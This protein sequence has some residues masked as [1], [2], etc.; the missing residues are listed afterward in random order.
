MDGQLGISELMSKMCYVCNKFEEEDHKCREFREIDLKAPYLS[1]LAV[2]T[3]R[4]IESDGT[5]N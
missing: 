1:S 4:G 3:R 2:P 5:V